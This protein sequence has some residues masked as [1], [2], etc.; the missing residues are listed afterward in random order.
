MPL[1]RLDSLIT[2]GRVYQ[3]QL[4]EILLLIREF[5]AFSLSQT[6]LRR[7][8]H[9]FF[10]ENVP[11][12]FF[13][14]FLAA[15]FFFSRLP[16]G[17]FLISFFLSLP[18]ENFWQREDFRVKVGNEERASE[19]RSERENRIRNV[20]EDRH[21]NEREWEREREEEKKERENE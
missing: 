7:R 20:R 14:F 16:G 12:D 18:Q 19:R 6:T 10:H 9:F 1:T 2:G 11:P 3:N 13:S 15:R 8:H 21:G 4:R 17:H 5:F